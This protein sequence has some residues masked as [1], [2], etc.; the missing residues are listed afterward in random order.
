MTSSQPGP[1]RPPR[2]SRSRT[3]DRVRDC[4]WPRALR[5]H[6]FAV[7]AV[8]RA[9][10]VQRGSKIVF[11]RWVAKRLEVWVMNADGSG[12]QRVAVAC[13]DSYSTDPLGLCAFATAHPVWQPGT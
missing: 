3:A 12:R 4:T 2:S 1:C 10:R 5:P 11:D 7:P 9:V 6:R 8:E 13:D